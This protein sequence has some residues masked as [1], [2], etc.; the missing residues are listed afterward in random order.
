MILKEEEIKAIIKGCLANNQQSQNLLY[1]TFYGFVK[2]ICLR[3][4]AS[5]DEAKDMMQTGFLKVFLNI[6]KYNPEFPF[7]VWLRT[8]IVN[9]ALSHN[10]DHKKH[11]ETERID[12]AYDILT[13][14]EDLLESIAAEEIIELVQ[15]L[16]PSYRNAF[17]LHAVDGYSHK[18]I[19]DLLQINE[20]S[21][22]TNYMKARFK[23]QSLL[24]QIRPELENRIDKIKSNG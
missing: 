13:I 7:T 11:T 6:E 1:K 15:K 21:S 22:R 4:S 17:M 19:A 8:V 16:S 14:N 3:Y 20:V 18:E 24:L 10:R 12:E 23:L 9:N 5:Q 2:S